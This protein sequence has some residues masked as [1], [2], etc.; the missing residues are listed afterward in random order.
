MTPDTLATIVFAWLG[1][2]VGS[3]LN[4]CIHRIA[5]GVSVSSKKRPAAIRR[6]PIGM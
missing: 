2:S 1:L 4:V 3:F 6:L 5:R